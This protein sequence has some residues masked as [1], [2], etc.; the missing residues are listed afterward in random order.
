MF[1]MCTVGKQQNNVMMGKIV[2]AMWIK[3]KVLEP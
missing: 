2:E 1:S 3:D